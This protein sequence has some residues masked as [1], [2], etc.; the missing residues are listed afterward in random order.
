MTKDELIEILLLR[1]RGVLHSRVFEPFDTDSVS[2]VYLG[3][4]ERG[5]LIEVPPEPGEHRS[6]MPLGFHVMI[7]PAG[8]AR[9]AILEKMMVPGAGRIE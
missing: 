5:H 9:L 6:T 2:T 8:R 4:I 7:S 1:N 3:L